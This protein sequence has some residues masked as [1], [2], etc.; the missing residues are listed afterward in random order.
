VWAYELR[1]R[2]GDTVERTIY[3]LEADAEGE[4]IPNQWVFWSERLVRSNTWE[5]I[6]DQQEWPWE[7]PPILHG[8]NLPKPNDFYGYSDLE[9]ADL[10]DAI[11]FV[12]GNTNRILRLYAHPV[13]Y[14]Y[15][16]GGEELRAD[17]G[18]AIIGRNPEAF[19]KYLEMGSQLQA[20]HDY[21]KMLENDF[22][23]VTRVPPMDPDNLRLG[24]QSGFA[25]RVLHGPLL[26]KTETKRRLYGMAIIELNRRL[27]DMMG[28]GEENLVNLHWEDPL[29]LDESAQNESDRF[30]HEAEIVSRQTLA[31]R[32]GY[33]WERE[34]E[35]IERE[36]AAREALEKA[37]AILALTNAGGSLQGAAEVAGL[38]EEQVSRLLE[39]EFSTNGALEQ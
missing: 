17:P 35:L 18:M 12:S 36:T 2:A 34:Q 4:R 3:S 37:N 8:K 31:E 26:E 16:F 13:L 9:D 28:H 21:F 32:R 39:I 24:A 5:V 15:G 33:I 19:L 30:D 38:T 14:G 22:F 20:S 29:P 6:R 23:R 1:F 27:A 25:L 7:W 10:N 11:N